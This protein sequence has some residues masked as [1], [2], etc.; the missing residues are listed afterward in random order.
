[1]NTMVHTAALPNYGA[2]HKYL[3]GTGKGRD[4]RADVDGNAADI[5]ADDFALAGMEHPGRRTC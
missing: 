5:V 4:A 3:A 1:V 2:G